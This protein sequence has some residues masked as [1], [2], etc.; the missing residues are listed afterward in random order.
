MWCI[1]KFAEGQAGE[2]ASGKVGLRDAALCALGARCMLR[3]SEI[4]GLRKGD[5]SFRKQLGGK[6]KEETWLYVRVKKS[7]TDQ[8]CKGRTIPV[9][10][11]R[12]AQGCP[13]ES[14]IKYMGLDRRPKDAWLFASVQGKQL[15]GA[16]VS[17]IVKRVA[18]ETGFEGPVSGHSLRIGG[19]CAAAEAGLGIEAIRAIGGWLGDS[20]FTYVRAGVVPAMKAT[21]RMWADRG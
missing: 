3:P 6:W 1:A 9:E 4:V 12:S 11:A 2:G 16:A 14:M 21:E 18:R 10:P 7:K 15:S 17:A 20:V 13:V 19:A 8:M 5:I